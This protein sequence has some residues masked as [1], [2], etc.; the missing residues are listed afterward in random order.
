LKPQQADRRDVPTQQCALDL[1]TGHDPRKH[2]HEFVEERGSVL[3][4][5]LREYGANARG[6]E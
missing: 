1:Y 4:A 3:S 2:R 6:L 5:A